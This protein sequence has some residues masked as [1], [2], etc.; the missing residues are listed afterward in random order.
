MK[1]MRTRN[2]NDEWEN[3]VYILTLSLK[4]AMQGLFS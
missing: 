2:L 1:V 3:I 4:N